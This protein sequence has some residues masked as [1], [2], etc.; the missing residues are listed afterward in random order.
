MCRGCI[1][2]V[3]LFSRLALWGGEEYIYAR[4]S[5][6]LYDVGLLLGLLWMNVG[7]GSLHRLYGYGSMDA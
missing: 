5:L 4:Y 1:V 3:F 6:L 2:L 7:V